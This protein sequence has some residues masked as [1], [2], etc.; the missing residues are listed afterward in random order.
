MTRRRVPRV[1]YS[2]ALESLTYANRRIF[3]KSTF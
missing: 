1:P 2:I 3:R